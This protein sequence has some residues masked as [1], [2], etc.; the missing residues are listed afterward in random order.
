MHEYEKKMLL[1]EK[2]Y[3]Y[4]LKRSK[5]INQIEQTNFYF[6]TDDLLMNSR[7]I[8]CRIRKKGN[9]YKAIVK[10]H[11]GE[12]GDCSIEENLYKKDTFDA[13]VF[14]KMGL[15]LQGEL[16][17][18]RTVIHKDVFCEIVLDKNSYLGYTDFELEIEYIPE[19]EE[20]ALQHLKSIATCFAK[21]NITNS[22]EAFMLRINRS[23]S[24]SKRFFERKGGNY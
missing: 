15:K 20:E 21:A 2:E 11:V 19:H 7:G 24:K 5:I 18:V 10:W 6:D 8:T 4:L 23:M 17:T 14:E 12:C 22:E 16:L 9:Q 1:S 13:I 3:L